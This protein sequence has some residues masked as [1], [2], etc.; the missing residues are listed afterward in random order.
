MTRRDKGMPRATLCGQLPIVQIPGLCKTHSDCL[1]KN[2]RNQLHKS[3]AFLVLPPRNSLFPNAILHF[4]PLA[5]YLHISSRASLF[6]H[7]RL[8]LG[9]KYSFCASRPSFRQPKRFQLVIRADFKKCLFKRR[10]GQLLY[11]PS[12]ADFSSQQGMS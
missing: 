1:C 2:M 3:N 4:I 12:S 5:C 7:G 10:G 11:M 9:M 6:P 8:A